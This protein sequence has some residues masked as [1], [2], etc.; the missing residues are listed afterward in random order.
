MN[1]RQGLPGC[2][3]ERAEARSCDN[4]PVCDTLT[5]WANWS[6]CSLNC[7]MGAEIGSRTR[8]RTCESLVRED[9]A[10]RLCDGDLAE[11]QKCNNFPCLQDVTSIPQCEP[12][13]EEVECGENKGYIETRRECTQEEID[14][15]ECTEGFMADSKLCDLVA[16]ERSRER[17][18]E[19]AR[20]ILDS[21]FQE[22]LRNSWRNTPADGPQLKS[23]FGN[24]NKLFITASSHLIFFSP[25]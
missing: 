23:S 7:R 6:S 14:E 19:S 21:N 22:N 2:D 13:N 1:A 10:D 17:E 20:T 18:R 16:C 15:Q 3:G 9:P 12:I 4:L 24:G 8:Q 5:K 11:T 25:P